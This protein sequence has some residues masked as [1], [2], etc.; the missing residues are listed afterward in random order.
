MKRPKGRKY[1]NLTARGGHDLLRLS[2]ERSAREGLHEDRELARGGG[3]PRSLCEPD[4]DGS[5]I[6][7]CGS[8]ATLRRVH[9][10][11]SARS[12]RTP[13]RHAHHS[14]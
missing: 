4:A 8:D 9:R 13:C 12:D 7:E 11:V 14:A 3:V 10:G 1:R 6:R 5:E 2:H